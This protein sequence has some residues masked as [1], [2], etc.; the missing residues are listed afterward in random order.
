MNRTGDAYRQKLL[1]LVEQ[2]LPSSHKITKQQAYDKERTFA[3]A[4]HTYIMKL[5]ACCHRLLWSLTGHLDLHP[6]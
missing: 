4:V 3:P 2:N 5:P 6:G 1:F